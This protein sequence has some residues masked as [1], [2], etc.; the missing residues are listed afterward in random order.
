MM[1]EKDEEV[2]L[3]SEPSDPPKE[4][5]PEPDENPNQGFM[6]YLV[7]VLTYSISRNIEVYVG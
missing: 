5:E 6:Y 4:A 7:R 2:D 1:K 3:K